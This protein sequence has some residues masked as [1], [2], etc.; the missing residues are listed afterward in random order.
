MSGFRELKVL[1]V[2]PVGQS[3]TGTEFFELVLENLGWSHWVPGQFLMVRPREWSSER[4]WA[5]PFSIASGDE[6]SLTLFIQVVGS[7]TRALSRLDTGDVVM[8]WG[9]LGNGFTVNPDAK[10]L[11][12]AGGVGIAPFRGFIE[13][14]PD[15]NGLHLL[16]AHRLPLS[17]Y[18]FERLARV[19]P[20]ECVMEETPQDL[21]RIIGLILTR[22]EEYS[23]P[24]R[25][26]LACGP[27]PFLRTVRQGA[28]DFGG[29]V[30]LSLEG[31]MACGV[32]AC[33]GCVVA[34][35]GGNMVRVCV[36]GPV[37]QAKEVVL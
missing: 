36:E 4:L 28:L 1:E 37:F 31:R 22:M 26:V 3:G 17:C 2:R 14:H 19:V 7:G 16:F 33:L 21:K 35:D 13:R 6:G 32:G 25:V 15:P 9:P 27:L 10:V 8:A 29:D 23:R 24:G 30:Q 12:L 5:R 34:D 18:P 11:L 20:G